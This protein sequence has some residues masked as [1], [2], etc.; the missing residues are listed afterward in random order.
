MVC[1]VYGVTGRGGFFRDVSLRD[2]VRRQAVTVMAAIAEGVDPALRADATLEAPW[3]SVLRTSSARLRA[4]LFVACD[5]G[6]LSDVEL[7]AL[8]RQLGDVTGAARLVSPPDNQPRSAIT[9]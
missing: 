5:Q 3:R 4:Y 1:A 7:D 9:G 8:V 6:Y 2:E